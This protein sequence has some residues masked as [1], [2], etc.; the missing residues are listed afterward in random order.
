MSRATWMSSLLTPAATIG[1]TISSRCTTKSTTTGTSLID[2][3]FSI[4]A[5]TSSG[6]SSAFDY[7]CAKAVQAWYDEISMHDFNSNSFNY[8]TGQFTQVVWK[9]STGLGCA[10]AS[11]KGSRWYESYVVCSYSPA[12][13]YQGQFI[14]NVPRPQ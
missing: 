1:Q 12:G 8:N 4:V 2:I 14:Q 7:G 9:S 11:G 3:A 10:R 5:S 13:N 6:R